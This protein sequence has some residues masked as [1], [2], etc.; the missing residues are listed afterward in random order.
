MREPSLS[1]A[2]RELFTHQ[3]ISL[4]HRYGARVLTKSD[5]PGAD[6]RHFTAAELMQLGER[7]CDALA[8]ASCHTREELERAMA[9]QLD[10]AVL[11]PVLEKG[12]ARPLGWRGFAELARGARIPV[13]A[14][15]GLCAGDLETA[16]RHGA[17]GL[18]MIRGS[19]D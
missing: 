13:Y 7:P 15:G 5:F 19:W 10:L 12:A 3:V 4:A 11:G 2:E 16:W 9:L 17:H 8:A 14:I 18:A 6:G 1:A